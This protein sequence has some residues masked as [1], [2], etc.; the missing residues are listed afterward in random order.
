MVQRTSEKIS[1]LPVTSTL[2]APIYVPVVTG[3]ATY[4]LRTDRMQSIF[5]ARAY[6]LSASGTGAANTTALQ[7]AIDAASAEYVSTGTPQVVLVPPGR[8]TLE[9]SLTK[10]YDLPLNGSTAEFHAAVQVASG[11]VFDLRGVT[12]RASAPVGYG[13]L[14]YFALFASPLNLTIGTLTDVTFLGGKFDFTEATW[15][16]G[17]S[18]IYGIA[19]TGVE[20]LNIRDTEAVSSGTKNGRLARIMNSRRVRMEGLAAKKVVQALYF[21]YCYDLKFS[22]QCDTFTECVD[23]DQACW[24]VIG[25]IVAENGE[26]EAQIADISSVVGGSFRIQGRNAGNLFIIYSKPE[27]WEQFSDWVTNFPLGSG[28]WSAS[29]VICRDVRIEATGE[30][31]HHATDLRTFQ[32]GLD[33]TAGSFGTYWDGKGPMVKNL[34][35]EVKA[36]DCDAALVY[37]CENLQGRVALEDV[38]T[39]TTARVNN[40]G[41]TL[42]QSRA[43]GAPLADSVLSGKLSVRIKNSDRTGVRVGIPTDFELECDVDGY[44]TQD[45]AGSGV[46]SGVFIEDLAQK[47]GIFSIKNFHIRNGDTTVS[48]VSLRMT[49]DGSSG[50]TRVRDLGGHRLLDATPCTA[51]VS[52]Y[53]LGGSNKTVTVDTTSATNDVTL[54]TVASGF[55]VGSV[56]VTNPVAITGDVTNYTALSLVRLRA[57]VAATIGGAVNYDNTNRAAGVV[58]ELGDGSNADGQLIAGDVLVLRCTRNGT[59]SSRAGLDVRITGI[60]YSL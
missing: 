27:C 5:D 30:D 28:G 8:Y 59:G 23:I 6:G 25:D 15:P 50:V 12:F 45:D 16:S 10:L 57:G 3:G 40:A 1:E 33:R 21:A 26:G 39:G 7:S 22:I 32:V 51:V 35:L 53:I 13:A 11:I 42:R 18:S 49:W 31:I 54:L 47:N 17:L 43:A 60:E 29:P 46:A 52:S 38:T 36:K 37:E 19:L 14:W 24:N 4:A 20:N 55:R 44:N 56:F 2:T 34:T 9:P 58:I 48:P 41:L